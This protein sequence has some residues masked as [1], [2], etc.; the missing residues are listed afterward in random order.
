MVGFVLFIAVGEKATDRAIAL[1]WAAIN[2]RDRVDS[3]LKRSRETN[4][5]FYRTKGN[6]I[7]CELGLGIYLAGKERELYLQEGG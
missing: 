7:T 2:A 5:S 6:K 3:V 4:S 1:F